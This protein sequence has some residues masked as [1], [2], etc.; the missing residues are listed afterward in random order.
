MYNHACVCDM[1][2]NNENETVMKCPLRMVKYYLEDR[3]L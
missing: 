2:F 3:E 1:S